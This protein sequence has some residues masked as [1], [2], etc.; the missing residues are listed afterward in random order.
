VTDALRDAGTFET[1]FINHRKAVPSA[2]SNCLLSLSCPWH[3]ISFLGLVSNAPSHQLHLLQPPLFQ[4][5]QSSHTQPQVFLLSAIL[6]LELSL[7]GSLGYQQAGHILAY[8]LQAMILSYVMTNIFSR[9]E[10]SRFWCVWA[11]FDR[12][13]LRLPIILRS[14]A[15]S[16]VSTGISSLV[17]RYTFPPGLP[18]SACAST[19]LCPS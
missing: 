4:S 10:I 5:T 1:A 6:S 13:H 12:L 17:I 11:F 8:N 7:S 3:P 16:S 14:M 19:K 18:N 9:M 2:T 15:P